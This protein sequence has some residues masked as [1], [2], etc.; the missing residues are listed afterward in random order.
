MEVDE[1]QSVGTFIGLRNKLVLKNNTSGERSILVPDG[2]ISF[3]KL[4]DHT[5]ATID[6]E[7]VTRTQ[8]YNFD[9]L[10]GRVIDNGSARSKLFSAYLHALTSFCLPDPLTGR[11]GTEQ[12]LSILDSAAVKSFDQ[13]STESFHILSELG[14]LTPGRKYYP[15]NER[16]MQTVKWSSQ[17]GFLAQHG[18]FIKLVQSIFDRTIRSKFFYQESW[19]KPPRFTHVDLGLLDRDDM[20]SATFRSSNFGAELHSSQYDRTYNSRD[21]WQESPRVRDVF[22]IANTVYRESMEPHFTLS[23]D[24]KSHLWHLLSS[25]EAVMG[26]NHADPGTQLTYDA[27]WM[28]E[29]SFVLKNWVVLHR[30]LSRGLSS[31]GKFDFALWLSTMAYGGKVDR[32]M[33]RGTP[34]ILR[35]AWNRKSMKFRRLCCR[36]VILYKTAPK[37]H[38]QDCKENQRVCTSSAKAEALKKTDL[39][40]LI[41]W[42]KP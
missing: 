40:P 34:F 42:R 5:Q 15:A 4:N 6:P 12:A 13:W 2:K 19:V 27:R 11:T 28:T 20:R 14:S 1:S 16:V 22:S 10:I 26:Q 37:T 39:L 3:R 18:G 41:A 31:V 23:T 29:T 9:N 24:L 17:L 32:S 8:A 33:H 35:R 36:H 30:D 7:T 38:F 21:R 25:V